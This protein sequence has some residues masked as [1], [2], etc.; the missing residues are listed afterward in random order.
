MRGFERLDAAVEDLR[1]AGV[2]LDRRACR[3][4]LLLELACGA[5][6]GDDLDARAATSPRAKSTSPRLSDTLSS[7]R[8]MRT[9]PGAADLPRAAATQSSSTPPHQP[10]VRRVEP[11][12][13]RGDQAARHAAAAGARPR[14][15]AARS[16][17]CPRWIRKL[18]RLLKDD[19]PAVHALV[20]EVD[21]HAGHLHAVLERLLD[22]PETRERPAAATG[23]TFTI[24]PAKRRMKAGRE[25]LHEAREHDQL[26]AALLEPV[27]ERAGRAAS[28]SG[29]SASAKTA[30]ST[31]AA[32][33]P[34]EPAR[35]GAAGEP[36]PTISMPSLRRGPCRAA[37][38]G[39]DPSPEMRTA[40]GKLTPRPTAQ[41]PDT[42]PPRGLAAALARSARPRARVCP[43][44]A[45]AT[46][47]P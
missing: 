34:L 29:W 21:G 19:R 20:D 36:P 8:R 12:A 44:A 7:A 39:C 16:P 35:L 14:G 10:R 30:V 2:V 37:P 4:P 1:E 13:P 22:R 42:G 11:H 40:I 46:D 5:A 18:E 26:R 25:Q 38:A 3:C 9:S 6:G 47:M 43:R 17:R 23:W 32:A 27:P 45:C 15:R 24:R 33:R 28:R 41:R 31:P